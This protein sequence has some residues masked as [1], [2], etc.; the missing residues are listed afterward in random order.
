MGISVIEVWNMLG[1]IPKYLGI[2]GPLVAAIICIGGARSAQA[3][4]AVMVLGLA[5]LA[6]PVYSVYTVREGMM[7]AGTGGVAA[8]SAGLAELL[9]MTPFV[10]AGGLAATLVWQSRRV[11]GPSKP[12]L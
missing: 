8:V 3:R 9:I 1:T 2:L 12:V 11:G 10:I 4:W 5:A 6:G 7:A